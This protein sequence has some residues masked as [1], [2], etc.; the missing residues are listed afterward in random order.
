MSLWRST[1]GNGS[2]S[3]TRG[4][5]GSRIECLDERIVPDTTGTTV[6]TGDSTV[7]ATTTTGTG[8]SSTGTSSTSG[9]NTSTGT[10][11][12]TTTTTGG[13]GSSTTTTTTTPGTTV[14]PAT[15]FY[16]VGA[17]GGNL[18]RVRVFDNTG[19]QKAE[20][21]AYPNFR[22]GV[23][24]T[25]GDVTGDGVADVITGP[26]P[27][28][29]PVV[30]VFDGVGGQ[31]LV[32]FEAY[33][34]TFRGGVNVA[35]GDVNGDGRADIVTGAG[36]GGG[37]HVKIFDG[38]A[39]F[40]L[41]GA[42]TDAGPNNY[43]IREFFA[44]DAQYNVGAR[45]A[46]AD[47][48]GDGKADVVT[49]PCSNGGPHVR[50]FSGAD[51]SVYREWFAYDAKFTSGIFVAAGDVNGDG[52]ADV[53]TGMGPNG[54][55]QVKVFDGRTTRQMRSFVPDAAAV[56]ASSRVTVFDYDKDGDADVVVGNMNA[57]TAYDGKTYVRTGGQ[58]P[59]DPT[60]VGG[61]SFG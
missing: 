36:D 2:R 25:M 30:R 10:T 45:V 4:R 12:T 43:L 16:A 14:Q 26:G 50:V 33:D 34:S 17:D 40:P 46:V 22:G 57:I 8:T 55:G 1:N 44:Y 61:V 38:R 21:I 13:N 51:G 24:A 56:R 48:D 7:P 52:K 5:I 6:P 15:V 59:F 53:V 35:V 9:T 31:L 19:T 18:S 3:H 37:S 11:T 29:K 28:G 58:T 39:M 54:I 60:H 42:V 32:S 41:E 47:I 49:S 23:R 27:G 20:F